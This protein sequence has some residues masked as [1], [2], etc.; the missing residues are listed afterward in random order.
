MPKSQ[1]YQCE[2]CDT[3]FTTKFSLTRHRLVHSKEKKY[4]CRFCDKKFALNQYRKEHECIHTNE[5]PYVCGVNGC[6]ERFRQRGKLSLHR[7]RH[8]GYQIK[9]Y[10]SLKRTESKE[11][12]VRTAINNPARAASPNSIIKKSAGNSDDDEVYHGAAPVVPCHRTMR[13]RRTQPK[14]SYEENDDELDYSMGYDYTQDEVTS[15]FEGKKTPTTSRRKKT[16]DT[17]D[18]E[19][20]PITK[21]EDHT[22]DSGDEDGSDF[23]PDY[24]RLQAL[25]DAA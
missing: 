14:Y 16:A 13:T 12:V 17:C 8:E 24:G 21:Q 22:Y 18:L 1:V 4:A 20:T 25:A 23:K 19:M 6:T 10:H 7:R 3:I 15:Q 5:K 2:T 9:K 11:N